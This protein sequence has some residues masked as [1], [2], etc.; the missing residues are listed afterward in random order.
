[1]SYVVDLVYY[2]KV[3]IGYVVNLPNI[4]KMSRDIDFWWYKSVCIF[5][6]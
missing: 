2:T 4:R 1:M 5:K 3:G 6:Q